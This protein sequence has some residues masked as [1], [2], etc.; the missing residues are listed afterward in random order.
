MCWIMYILYYMYYVI[1]TKLIVFYKCFVF[2]NPA[3]AGIIL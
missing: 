1:F 2:A 3:S